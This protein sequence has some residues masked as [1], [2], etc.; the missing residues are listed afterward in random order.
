MKEKKSHWLFCFNIIT[1][2]SCAY[3]YYITHIPHRQSIEIIC[4]RAYLHHT[5]CAS[6]HALSLGSKLQ[7]YFFSPASKWFIWYMVPNPICI[8]MKVSI[9]AKWKVAAAAAVVVSM[10]QEFCNRWIEW[11]ENCKFTHT[12]N[13]MHQVIRLVDAKWGVR[14]FDLKAM[15]CGANDKVK[16]FIYEL[17]KISMKCA[18]CELNSQLCTH[19]MNMEYAMQFTIP[20][21]TQKRKVNAPCGEWER[22]LF[23]SE[24]HPC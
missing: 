12:F 2:C 14:K 24:R 6:F 11:K 7:F 21:Q 15:N 13:E 23:Q 16:L 5:V 1:P 20:I 4:G 9:I 18:K 8:K 10:A 17:W 3:Y 19:H 22:D